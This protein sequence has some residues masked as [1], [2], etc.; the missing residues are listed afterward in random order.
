MRSRR[1]RRSTS[2]PTRNTSSSIPIAPR[3][4]SA[5]PMAM[6]LSDAEHLADRSAAWVQDNY[7]RQRAKVEQQRDSSNKKHTDHHTKLIPELE[8]RR[9]A[10]V[11]AAEERY[12]K[13]LAEAA[14]KYEADL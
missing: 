1:P 6:A 12:P 3:P 2:T 5:R 9:D 14:K 4:R 11:K 13:D 7:K 10:D 8:I